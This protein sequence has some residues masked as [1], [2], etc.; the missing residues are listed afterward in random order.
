MMI[1]TYIW[2]SLLWIFHRL[3]V[4]FLPP[5]LPE[6]SDMSR[7]LY[8]CF[9]NDLNREFPVMCHDE[10]TYYDL[11]VKIQQKKGLEDDV[12]QWDLYRPGDLLD[13]TKPFIPKAGDQRLAPKHQIR[14]KD[15]ESGDSDIDIVIVGGQQHQHKQPQRKDI[16]TLAAS[17]T[18]SR[19][20][21]TY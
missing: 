16:E 15:Q 11:K 18:P 2:D 20:S 17:G 19:H 6:T 4:H 21:F 3:P 8:C 14:H 9:E 12:D 7:K 5:P 13:K 1:V 10:D